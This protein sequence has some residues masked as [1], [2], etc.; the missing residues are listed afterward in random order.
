MDT[1]GL[2]DTAIR[3]SSCVF[4]LYLSI[5][6]YWNPSVHLYYSVVVSERTRS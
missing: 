6:R 3:V 5:V 1:M 2:E 4:S